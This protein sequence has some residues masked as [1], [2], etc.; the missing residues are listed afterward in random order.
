[1]KNFLH[2]AIALMS[3]VMPA[4]AV[5]FICNG[6]RI[7]GSDVEEAV[8]RRT[9][10]GYL[11]QATLG[12]DSTST[13][14]YIDITRKGKATDSTSGYRCYIGTNLPSPDVRVW[15]G[16]KWAPCSRE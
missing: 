3:V 8:N 10:Q 12:G 15:V 9:G 2:L 13:Y 4:L 1:M 14:D 5:T 16:N 11:L 6:C 7:K